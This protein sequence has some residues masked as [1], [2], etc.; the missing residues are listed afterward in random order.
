MAQEQQQD[1]NAPITIDQR[2]VHRP[3]L[4]ATSRINYQVDPRKPL[5]AMTAADKFGLAVA[6][7]LLTREEVEDAVATQDPTVVYNS[8]KFR[9]LNTALHMHSPRWRSSTGNAPGA[10][11]FTQGANRRDP[12]AT[13][14]DPFDGF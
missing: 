8:A 2:H 5:Y 9:G 6:R 4:S 12:G 1:P 10:S 14:S 13:Q 3:Y 7:G 11:M